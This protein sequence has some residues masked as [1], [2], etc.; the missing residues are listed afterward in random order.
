MSDWDNEVASNEGW[1]LYGLLY[2]R[3]TIASGVNANRLL[4]WYPGFPRHLI[5]DLAVMHVQQRAREGSSY[6]VEAL[7]RTQLL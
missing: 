2:G 3:P 7:A 5:D 1:L 6:H 4:G